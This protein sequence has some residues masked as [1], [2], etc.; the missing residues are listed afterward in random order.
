VDIRWAFAVCKRLVCEFRSQVLKQV[1]SS[2]GYFSFPMSFVVQ[3]VITAWETAKT[4][5]QAIRNGY[6]A[7][8]W[9]GKVIRKYPSGCTLVVGKAPRILYQLS[10]RTKSLGCCLLLI[11]LDAFKRGMNQEERMASRRGGVSIRTVVIAARRISFACNLLISD[12]IQISCKVF[13]FFFVW[14]V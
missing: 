12:V 5:L 10:R 6:S 8:E 9:M 3:V 4:I 2:S 11:L 13:F 14:N 7:C 1:H